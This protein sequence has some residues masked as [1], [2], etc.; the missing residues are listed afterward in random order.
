MPMS[1]TP[2][3]FRQ[4]MGSFATGV[5]VVCFRRRDGLPGGLTVNSFTS[6]SLTP[7]LV[8]VCIDKKAESHDELL[9]AAS[10]TVNVLAADQAELSRRFATSKLT[11]RERFEGVSWQAA[12]SGA[13]VLAGCLSHVDCAIT[14]RHE[15]GDH[16]IFVGQVTAAAVRDGEP[17]LFYRGKYGRMQP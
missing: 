4:T 14:A 3:E 17:L 9:A 12:G 8:L 2:E 5:T 15:A 16:T 11:A 13:P 6:V 1:I 7:P 10:F